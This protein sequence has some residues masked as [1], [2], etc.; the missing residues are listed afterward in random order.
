VWARA[1][2]IWHYVD[3]SITTPV[4]KIE[5]QARIEILLRA[6]RLSLDLTMRN[7]DLEAFIQAMSHDLRA[8]VRAVSMFAE[9]LTAKVDKLDEDAR[10][11]LER[12]HWSAAEMRDLIESLLNFSRLGR[13]EIRYH[14]IDLRTYIENCLDNLRTEIQ[15]RHASV[16]VK[17][18]RGTVHTDPTLLKIAL[19]NLLSN[20]IKFVPEGVQ[21]D[22]VVSA[23]IRSDFCRIQVDDNG[24]GIPAEDQ[25][26]IFTPFVRLHS[27]VEFPGVGLGLPAV[28]KALEL[29]GGRVGVQSSP[30]RGS[31]FWI[32][33][34]GPLVETQ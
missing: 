19:T 22:I 30:G 27:E 2:D 18:R 5:L 8:S 31:T 16:R 4:S 15:F 21:P 20:A 10:R 29:M 23:S 32:E 3:D 17:A 33:F 6:R 7:E 14:P 26:R 13:G 12:I 24:V 28:R 9:S 34:P 11:D 25:Q 1:P